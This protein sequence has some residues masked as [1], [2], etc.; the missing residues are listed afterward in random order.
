MLACCCK[1]TGINL[2][3][4]VVN[5]N[6][7]LPRIQTNKQKTFFGKKKIFLNRRQ[8]RRAN[9]KSF[10]L[11]CFEMFVMAI[12]TFEAKWKVWKMQRHSLKGSSIKITFCVKCK[13]LFR[14]LSEYKK[15]LKKVARNVKSIWLKIE[16][17]NNLLKEL[18][19]KWN[20]SSF[21]QVN[22][23]MCRRQSSVLISPNALL[24]NWKNL[25]LAWHRNE[26]TWKRRKKL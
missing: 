18:I 24:C 8:R 11:K 10:S 20:F 21:R 13:I 1:P 16:T 4:H 9:W 14:L 7:T 25:S 2:K 22:N 17:S 5:R 3:G 15:K 23:W 19:W 12:K 6:Y 26:I